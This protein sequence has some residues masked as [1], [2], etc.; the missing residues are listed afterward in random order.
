MARS[1]LRGRQVILRPLRREDSGP[2]GRFLR[3]P[4]ATRYLPYRVRRENGP[5]FVARVLREQVRGGGV[6][7]AVLEFRSREV[8]G[9]IRLFNWQPREGIAEIGYWVGRRHWGKGYGSE[10]VRLA[11]RFGFGTMRLHRINAVVVAGNDRS[12]RALTK[13]G[14]RLEGTS[15]SSTRVAGGWRDERLFGLLRGELTPR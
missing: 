10:A 14:F 7:F 9:Q 13:A 5:Q 11:C 2:L 4:R 3:D 15:R 6:A 1:I 12:E 8:V